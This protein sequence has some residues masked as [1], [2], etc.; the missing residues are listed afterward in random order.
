M[1]AKLA[2][3]GQTL[4]CRLEENLLEHSLLLVDSRSIVDKADSNVAILVVL[5][6]L[7]ML[8]NLLLSTARPF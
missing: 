2:T 4:L 6:L 5:T 1:Q 3:L 7:Q 8:I